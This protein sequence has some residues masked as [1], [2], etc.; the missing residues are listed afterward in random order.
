[1]QRTAA[2]AA[3]VFSSKQEHCNVLDPSPPLL[4]GLYYHFY[5]TNI[6]RVYTLTYIYAVTAACGK[7]AVSI[8]FQILFNVPKTRVFHIMHVYMYI[9]IQ[10]YNMRRT[11]F[12]EIVSSWTARGGC[13]EACHFKLFLRPAEPKPSFI[14]LAPTKI[15]YG[16]KNVKIK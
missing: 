6:I 10:I 1:M 3:V 5:C 8:S 7:L 11:G 9:I 2:P 14:L 12:L 15:N 16:E 4:R 13:A